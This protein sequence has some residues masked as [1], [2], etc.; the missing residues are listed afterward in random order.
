MVLE[1]DA[2]CKLPPLSNFS[3]TGSPWFGRLSGS[4]PPVSHDG[5]AQGVPGWH[6]RA[7]FVAL[8][9]RVIGGP[10]IAGG[11][12]LAVLSRALQGGSGP[13]RNPIR[14]PQTVNLSPAGA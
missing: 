13:A 3:H 5:L 8:P 11:V 1:R 12:V 9:E 4:T 7:I 6:R 10:Q 14:C 2:G